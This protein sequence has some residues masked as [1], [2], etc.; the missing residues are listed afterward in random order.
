MRI[1]FM[2]T[3][4]F[5]VPSLE[6]IINAGY[7]VPLVVSVPDKRQGRGRKSAP[8]PVKARALE[9]G[10]QT[11]TPESLKDPE[12]IQLLRSKE[13]DLICVVAFRILPE[14]V[15][16]VP[17]LGSFN[18]HGSL[19]PRY[20]GAAPIQRAIMAGEA[21]TGV[22]TFFLKKKVDTGDM[23]LREKIP[24][25]PDMTAGELHDAMM[26]VGADAVVRTLRMIE[27]GNLEPLRQ[28]DTQATPA[29]KIF[30]DDCRIDW[31]RAAAEVHNMVRGLSPYPGAFTGWRGEGVKILRTRLTAREGLAPGELRTEGERLFAGTGTEALEIL[32]LQREGRRAM[33]ADEFLRGAAIESGE[34]FGGAQSS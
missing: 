1:I 26:A 15:Y 9:L 21:E 27:S 19:L 23:I 25:G 2:G 14:E 22:T 5:A 17:R 24:I 4:E 6:A 10:L 12:F 28:D 29:P 16:T 31:N 34:S 11:A 13:P 33:A 7:E 20:R 30:R 8:S 3:P 32:Y 18:L